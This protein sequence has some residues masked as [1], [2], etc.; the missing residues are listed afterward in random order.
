MALLEV[1]NLCKDFGGL[2]AVNNVNFNLQEGQIFTLIGPNGAGK[3]TTFN[4]IAGSFPA[5]SG[6][7]RYNGEELLGKAAYQIA[8]KGVTRTFQ[9]TAVFHGIS[10]F[11]NILAAMHI[12]QKAT[13]VDAL[14]CTKLIRE[15]E[16]QIREKAVEILKFV[17][18]YEDRNEEAASLPYG[19]QRLLEIAIALASGPKL[20]LLDEPAA[21]LNPEETRSLM[22]LIRRI[23][24]SGV[25]VLLI[26]HNMNLVMD[27]SDY[28][29]VLDHGVVIAEGLPEEIS[30]NP[31]VIEAYLGKGGVE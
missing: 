21:G 10:V 22:E 29:V 17:G 12:N 19:K 23:R 1:K 9:I 20:V 15:E 24:V 7:V 3:T 16:I 26:E 4:M 8:Q 14:F 25:S 5:T 31:R 2:V 27:I 11:N 6:S 13:F 28:I 18:L 30:H